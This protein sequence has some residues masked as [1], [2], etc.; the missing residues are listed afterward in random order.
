MIF[1][2]RLQEERLLEFELNITER[3][4]YII[5]PI[6]NITIEELCTLADKFHYSIE[7]PLISTV[8]HPDD[9]ITTDE[10]NE[11][12]TTDSIG[13]I[14]HILAFANMMISGN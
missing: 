1:T 14:S 2:I 13:A 10:L 11:D 9:K 4:L 12:Y 8:I 3:T 5:D 7:L 6:P